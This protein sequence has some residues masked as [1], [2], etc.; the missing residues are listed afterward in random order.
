MSAEIIIGYE[1]ESMEGRTLRKLVICDS[2]DEYMRIKA[3]IEK[4]DGYRVVEY[5]N[6][7]LS[8]TIPE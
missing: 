8:N 5:D 7:L 2:Y 3:K 4:T 1:Y 6:V